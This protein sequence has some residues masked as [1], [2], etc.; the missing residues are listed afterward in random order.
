MKKIL[1][2]SLIVVVIV[3]VAGLFMWRGE[4]TYR[5]KSDDY[6]IDGNRIVLT[7]AQDDTVEHLK[8]P[9]EIRGRPVEEIAPDAFRNFNRLKNVEIGKNVR[10][11]NDNA[12]RSATRLDTVS[13]DEESALERIGRSAFQ[14]T[15]ALESVALPETVNIVDAHAFE[16]ASALHEALLPEGLET[17]GEGAF[18]FTAIESIELPGALSTL[19][20]LAFS[21]TPL[22]SVTI[23]SG[24]T[25]IGS[26]A[27]NNATSLE[28]V[29]FASSSALTTI[30]AQAFAR[31][32]SLEE[33]ELP[34]SLSRLESGAFEES[35]IES[36]TLGENVEYIGS[37]A[38]Y[39]S[40][41]QTLIIERTFEA[42]V[43]WL[44]APESTTHFPKTLAIY[45]DEDSVESY[46]EASGFSHYA[47]QIVSI[48]TLED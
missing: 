47:D 33:I 44:G 30:E 13:F 4:D 45:V 5:F 27:F 31:T 28:T 26:G 41:L 11:I 9:D 23:P 34:T 36:L 8:I 39:L 1:T 25:V 38:F 16:G 17:I 40:N 24:V 12:F 14:R 7:G 46:R 20:A 10:V 29:H 35:G 15:L 32:I 22:R 48:E 43:P 2:A 18:S 37:R 21:S 19:G 42:G 3:L 6:T